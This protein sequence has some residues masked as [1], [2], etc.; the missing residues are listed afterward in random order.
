MSFKN[1]KYLIFFLSILAF[2]TSIF[3]NNN[4][5]SIGC[6]LILIVISSIIYHKN[7]EEFTDLAED[8][9]K[10]HIIKRITILGILVLISGLLGAY[11]LDEKVICENSEKY[12]AAAIVFLVILIIGN[13]A[14]QI[15]FNR[16]TG[17][18]LPWIVASE[19]TWIFAH[20]VL[21]YISLPLAFIYISLVPVIENFEAITLLTIMLWIGIPGILSYNFYKNRKL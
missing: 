19:T 20:R 14:P 17:L 9:P 16:Y 3:V 6:T 8:N 5:V 2:Y 21:G 15:P 11:L 18:R 12:I 4:V 13:I 1:K 10:I 7:I